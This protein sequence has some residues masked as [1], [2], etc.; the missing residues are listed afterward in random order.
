MTD[1]LSLL[2]EVPYVDDDLYDDVLAFF[3]ANVAWAGPAVDGP[4]EVLAAVSREARVLDAREYETWLTLYAPTCIYWVPHHDIVGDPRVEPSLHFD[5]R[6]R[7]GDRVALLRTG[8]LHAQTPPSRT[9]R[10]VS[11]LECRDVGA[12]V[13]DVHS[14]LTVHEQRRDRKQLYVGRQFHRLERAQGEWKIRYR[15]LLLLDR[16][17]SQGNTTFI[18]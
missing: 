5:D 18:L 4:A 1:Y 7:M 2:E 8:Y 16:D 13:A 17:V 6:R 15:V 3:R 11:N 12:D 9:C 14:C 10:V